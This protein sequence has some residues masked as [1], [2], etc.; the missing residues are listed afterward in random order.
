MKSAIALTVAILGVLLSMANGY[1]VLKTTHAGTSAAQA[2]MRSPAPD[3]SHLSAI[4]GETIIAVTSHGFLAIIPATLLYVALAVL[5]VRQR[6]FYSC[7][8]VAAIYFLLVPPFATL[9]G[10]I[11]LVALRRRKSEFGVP[12][13]PPSIHSPENEPS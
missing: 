12:A 13:I 6:W 9:Y 2:F 1:A 10:I 4:V 5:R 3:P 8:T 7:T 11:L